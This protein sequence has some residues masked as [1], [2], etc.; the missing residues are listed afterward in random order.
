MTKRKAPQP[1]LEIE[2]HIDLDDDR[3][4]EA[5]ANLL[6]NLSRHRKEPQ[7]PANDEQ[8]GDNRKRPPRRPR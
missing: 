3:V 2:L 5:I 4:I 8:A 6:L 7:P 1:Q